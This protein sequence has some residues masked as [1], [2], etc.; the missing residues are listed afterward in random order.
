MT[1]P[2]PGK[3]QFHRNEALDGYRGF[4]CLLVMLGHTQ[5]HGRTILPGAMAAMDLFFV[6]SGFLIGGLLLAEL[7]KTNTISVGQ[8]WKRRAIRLLPAF[9]LYYSI[10]A[11]VFAISKFRPI[12]GTDP[13]VSL[14][15]TAF[16]ASNWA[17]ARGYDLGVYFVT[18]SLSLEEQFY[19]LCPLLFLLL[20]KFFDKKTVLGLFVLGIFGVNVHRFFLFHHLAETD[21]ILIAFKAVFYRLDT[22]SDALLIGCAGAIFYNLYGDKVKIGPRVALCAAAALFGSILFVRD[23]PVAFHQSATSPFTEFLIAGGFTFF[24]LLGLLCNIH[25]LQYPESFLTKFFSTRFLIRIGTLSYSIYLWH[26]TVFGGLE[27]LLRD[28]NRSPALWLLKTGVA[29]TVAFS[30]GYASFRF[31][32]FPILDY[33]FRKRKFVPIPLKDSTL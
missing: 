4:G 20:F 3:N 16:Y 6:L 11:I 5:W 33:L 26:T 23:V 9:Y 22:R 10:V 18:W 28:L 25:V 15:S 14:L 31:V 29:F 32:E 2:I 17:V 27:I 24:S 8:F 13:Q 7:R 19:L 12:V 1:K 30:I 21:G